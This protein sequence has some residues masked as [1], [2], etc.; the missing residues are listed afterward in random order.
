MSPAGSLPDRPVPPA[1]E[2][3]GARWRAVRLEDLPGV[4][5]PCGT[6]RRAFAA[7]P[8]GRASVH[9]VDIS[10]DSQLHHHERLTEVYYVLEGEGRLE[11]D[12]E[13]VPLAPGVCVLIRPG[14][15]HRA[16]GRLR[17][18]NFVTPVFDPA[19]EWIEEG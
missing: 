13:E 8:E 10:E 14:C 18:L 17:L 9:L 3:G 12:G 5:C 15:R 6:S 2:T 16:R 4:P 7:D 11:V 1:E 19:D